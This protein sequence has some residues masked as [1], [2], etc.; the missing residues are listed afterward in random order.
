MST[1]YIPVPVVQTVNV[2]VFLHAPF[3]WHVPHTQ[4]LALVYKRGARLQ[5]QRGSQ[6]LGSFQAMLLLRV[7][8]PVNA[9][10]LVVILPVQGVP[11]PIFVHERLPSIEEGLQVGELPIA[12]LEFVVCSVVYVD[13]LEVEDHVDLAAVVLD[14][15]Q[16]LVRVLNERHLADAERIILLQ[17]LA[18]I[19]QVFV[20]PW[21]VGVE[22]IRPL[23]DAPRVLDRRVGEAL[24]LTD[25]VDHVHSEPICTFVEPEAHD[26]MHRLADGRVLPVEIWLLCRIEM[27]VIF[28]GQLI[29]L[30]RAPWMKSD[31]DCTGEASIPTLEVRDPVIRGMSVPV[32]VKPGRLPD[33]PI[34]VLIILGASRLLEPLVLVAGVVDHQVHQQ[35]HSPVMAA[36]D[37]PLD[38]NDRAVLVRDT[39]VVG[40]VVAHVDLRRLVGRT[41]PDNVH[42]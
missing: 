14:S 12:R 40:N 8:V 31:Q 2:L 38:I 37:Q 21:S 9:A 23:P 1:R 4:L 10:R 3:N 33:I 32:L 20:Q 29:E 28:T 36:L 26:I 15:L 7:G 42:S 27:E 6:H 24:I 18:Q 22:L 30:P 16:H 13:M 34:A 5:S 39:V 35:L 17:D 11:A 25:E 19:L 41:E